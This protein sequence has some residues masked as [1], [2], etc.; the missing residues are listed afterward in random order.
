VDGAPVVQRV[1]QRSGEYYGLRG[2]LDWRRGKWSESHQASWIAGEIERSQGWTSPRRLPPIQGL[3]RLALDLD[4][5]LSL[6]F[7]LRWALAQDQLHP[8]DRKDLR[9]C[10]DPVAPHKVYAGQDCPGSA[11]W[12]RLDLSLAYRSSAAA[13]WR[14]SI[15]NASNRPIK[16]HGS[17]TPAPGMTVRL[18]FQQRY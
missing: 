12:Y 8:S 14:L 6:G 2:R 15:E 16:A 9:I 10:T 1:N 5:K 3:H 13:S 17:G 11:A 4:R 7:A 18:S